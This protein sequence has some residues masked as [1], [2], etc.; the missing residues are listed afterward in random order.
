MGLLSKKS[1]PVEAATSEFRIPSLKEV[2]AEYGALLDRRAALQTT[3]ARLQAEIRQCQD[4][5]GRQPAPAF[6]PEVAELLGEEAGSASTLRTQIR[7]KLAQVAH[8]EAAL[9]V[10]EDRIRQAIGTASVKA[11]ERVRPEYGRRVQAICRALLALKEAYAE[12]DS[13]KN[14]LESEDIQWTRLT[15]LLPT[16]VGSLREPD[17]HINRYFREAKDA[18][19]W[20]E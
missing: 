8:H 2:D 7:E 5:L 6:R 18:G 19:Y 13:L 14:G 1:P 20:D 17:S 15:P 10:I 4:E 11:C 16:F 3:H 9:R 12:L